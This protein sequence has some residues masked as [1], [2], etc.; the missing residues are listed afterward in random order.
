MA[1]PLA[2]STAA[3]MAYI[4]VGGEV[5]DQRAIVIELEVTPITPDN[6][7]SVRDELVPFI[8]TS[9]QDQGKEHLI[10]DG[11]LRIQIER[12]F[13]YDAAIVV[14]LTFLSGVALETYK[15]IILPKLR[16]KF[17]ITERQSS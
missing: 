13:P 10:E 16:E 14:G 17:G 8:H 5:L 4:A 12:P 3:L 7:D 15:A 2:R 11:E 6:V 1:W 9:L